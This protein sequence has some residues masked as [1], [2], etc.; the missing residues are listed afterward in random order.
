MNRSDLESKIQITWERCPGWPS[1]TGVEKCVASLQL[2]REAVLDR[3]VERLF[4][5]GPVSI[6]HEIEK[7]VRDEL[8]R[9]LIGDLESENQRLRAAVKRWGQAA[10]AAE[11]LLRPGFKTIV[12]MEA[13]LEED[14]R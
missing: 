9:L 7:R 12:E 14:L 13:K 2:R 1:E 11:R 5:A 10:L 8:I 3:L 6:R 4:P